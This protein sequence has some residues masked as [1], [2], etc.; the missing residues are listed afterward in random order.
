MR[1]TSTSAAQQ[2]GKAS[3]D[4][5]SDPEHACSTAY[6]TIPEEHLYY[7]RSLIRKGVGIFPEQ[8]CQRHSFPV[9]HRLSIWLKMS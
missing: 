1:H 4:L 3:G 8:L 7:S 2:Q 5:L 6:N 9:F